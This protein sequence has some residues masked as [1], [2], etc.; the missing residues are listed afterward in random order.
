[1]P[2]IVGLVALTVSFIGAAQE[3]DNRPIY[4]VMLKSLEEGFASYNDELVAALDARLSSL[5]TRFEPERQAIAEA[6]K[7]L[8]AERANREAAFNTKRD[9]L[10]ERIDAINTQIAL[11]TGRVNEKRRIEKRH[12][13]RYASDPEITALMERIAAQIAEIDTIRNRY[14]SQVAATQRAR[15]ALTRQFEEYMS[16]GDPLAYG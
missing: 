15:A 16:A 11:R 6:T 4:Y 13:A 1:M 5:R 9:A 12:A 7:A 2:G 3:T 8:E 10:N 14:L